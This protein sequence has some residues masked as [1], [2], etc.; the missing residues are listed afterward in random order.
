MN[1]QELFRMFDQHYWP[2]TEQE[3]NEYMEYLKF[4]TI[5]WSSYPYFKRQLRDYLRS[6][7]DRTCTVLD[8]GCG[9]GT[10]Y[11]LLKNDYDLID[12]VEGDAEII[13][14]AG[15]EK[16]YH[17]VINDDA[18]NIDYDYYDIIIIGDCLEHIEYSKAYEL[19]NKLCDK[20]KILVITIPY[21]LPMEEAE[22]KPYS[23]HRQDDLAPDNMGLRYPMLKLKWSNQFIGVYINEK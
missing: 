22:G 1:R 14:K 20:C 11:Y 18:C 3:D 16:L 5:P 23:P 15:L 19:V 4:N 6:K 13:E 12:G 7:Y 21:N 17:K 2:E 9:I 10:Y 8:I